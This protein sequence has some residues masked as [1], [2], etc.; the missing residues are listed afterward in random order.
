MRAAIGLLA[1]LAVFG[2]IASAQPPG[3]ETAGLYTPLPTA[4]S[5]TLL[6]RA[7]GLK[8]KCTCKGKTSPVTIEADYCPD[9]VKPVCKCESGGPEAMCPKARN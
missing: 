5:Q 6:W 1:A 9:G 3:I 4:L 7:G 2:G 8:L